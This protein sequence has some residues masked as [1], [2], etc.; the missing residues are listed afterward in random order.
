MEFLKQ[1]SPHLLSLDGNGSLVI[2]EAI[3]LAH[4]FGFK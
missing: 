3:K 4:Q 1:I 2:L